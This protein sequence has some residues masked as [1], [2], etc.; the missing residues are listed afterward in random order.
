MQ[1]EAAYEMLLKRWREAA[2]LATSSALLDWDQQT[3]MPTSGTEYRGQQQ[4]LLA[5]L[6]HDR[7]TDPG[8]E[9]LL[10]QL[11][12][13]PL[14]KDPESPVGVNVREIRRVYDKET[15]LPKALVEEIA[16]TT[17]QAQFEWTVARKTNDFSHFLPWLTR[18]FDLVRQKALALAPTAPLYDTLLDDYEMGAK[19]ANVDSI[20]RGLREQLVPMVRSILGAARQPDGGILERNYPVDRQQMFGEMAAAEMG[21]DFSRGRLDTTTHPFC[22]TLG[23]NDC[24]ILTRYNPRHFSDAF[25]STLHEAGHGMYEQGLDR[26][27]FGLP[28]GEA[29]SLGIHESQSRL[30]ENAVG[31]SHSFWRFYY[32]RSRAFFRDA[33]SGVSMD[34]FHFAINKVAPSFIR[35]EADEV[36]YNLHIFIRYELEQAILN[37]DLSVEGLP[38]AWNEKCQQYL[39]IHPPNDGNGCLQDVHWSVGLIGY[40]PTYTLGNIY[41]AQLFQKADHDLGGLEELIGRGQFAELL[42]WLREKVHRHGKRY[43]PA[44]L[45]ERATGSPPSSD[46]LLNSLRTKFGELY[47]LAGG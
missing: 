41:G 46:A 34:E 39:G 40:F 36:T 20:F 23:P 31:R 45:V 10:Q 8:I 4:A 25:F 35:V 19:S 12:A 27:E 17:A 30:W 38:A 9:S 21:F 7:V 5:G 22:T 28:M 16:R 44:E 37:E 26:D 11:E 1:D 47:G 29:V 2:L 24:R 6:R 14:A 3:S 42:A 18:V 33:L 13:S 15:K 43:K 32:Q